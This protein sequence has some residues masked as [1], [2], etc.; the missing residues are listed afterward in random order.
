M[1]T[2]GKITSGYT[3]KSAHKI[4]GYSAGDTLSSR[5]SF[6]TVM[7]DSRNSGNNKAAVY[8]DI[9]ESTIEY[10][11]ITSI[12]LNYSARASNT[13]YAN[14]TAR[15]GYVDGSGE[16]KYTKTHTEEVPKKS[17]SAKP[18]NDKHDNPPRS[19]TG[20]YRF[21]I[22]G[23]NEI[24]LAYLDWIEFTNISIEIT[25]TPH[26]CNWV[27]TGVTKQPTC[28]A[29]GSEGFK[30]SIC[31]ATKTTTLTINPNNHTGSQQTLAAVAATCTTDGKTEG[32]KWSCCGA[33]ITA[34]QTIPALGHDW[35]YTTYS[36]SEDMKTHTAKRVC[37]RDAS[38]V[39]S[40]TVP[41][42]SEIH[43]E[44]TCTQPG[45]TKYNTPHTVPW[46]EFDA[47]YFNSTPA[48]GHNYA[49]Q[50]IKPT[51][52]VDGYTDHTCSRCSHNYKDNY[53][54][55]KI[56]Y[57]TE[58]PSEIYFDGQKVKEVYYGTTKVFGPK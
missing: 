46:A 50:V 52:A 56:F 32:K 13:F 22:G 41:V 29:T 6:K 12:I 30:C 28:T 20:G 19:N 42:T 10:G 8:V 21:L 26:T 53:T 4:E 15:S 49:S 9:A 36:F 39:E 25:Y 11:T 24:A 1:A 55:N 16:W 48:L 18:F 45:V 54:I 38:H 40:E 51:A 33:I 17:S 47:M 3:L 14:A 44:P 27:S 34:Q 31:G 57:G 35:N 23:V 2:T 58:Q 7:L 5:T 37:K 43:S